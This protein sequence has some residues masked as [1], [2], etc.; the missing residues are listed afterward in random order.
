MSNSKSDSQKAAIFN[1]V[2]EANL[3]LKINRLEGE[4]LKAQ[5]DLRD[6]L[7]KQDGF[8]N[9]GNVK[10]KFLGDLSK[11]KKGSKNKRSKKKSKKRSKRR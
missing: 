9:L 5:A 1:P 3:R 7:K 8:K 2:Q 6:C 11:N 4:L 10:A